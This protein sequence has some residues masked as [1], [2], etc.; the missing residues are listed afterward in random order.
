MEEISLVTPTPGY[1]IHN[2]SSGIGTIIRVPRKSIIKSLASRIL[3]S[4]LLP[5]SY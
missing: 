4:S 1:S 5:G 2:I 3:M